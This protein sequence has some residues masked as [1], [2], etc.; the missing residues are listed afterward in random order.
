MNNEIFRAYD[1]RG[2]A[3]VDLTTDVV[4]NIGRAFGSLALEKNISTVVIGRDG[5][6]SGPSLLGA[7]SEG[8][9]LAGIHVVDIGLVPTPVLYFAC[10]LVGSNTGIALTGSHN[11][12]NYNGLKMVI[13]NR[14]LYGDDIQEIRRRIEKNLF[15]SGQGSYETRNVIHSYLE[16]IIK[17]IHLSKSFRIAIDCGNGVAGLLAPTLFRKLGCQV[18]PLYCDVDGTFPNHHP[19]PSDLDNLTDLMRL[20]KEQHCDLGFAFDGDGDR[21]GVVDATGKVIWPDRQ[22]MLFSED[23]L[24]RHPG[25]TI[26]YDVKCSRH[27]GEYIKNHGGK[28]IMWKT[29]HS[30]VKAKMRETNALLAGEMS[31]HIFFKERWYGFDDAL[32][33]ASRLLE[34]LSRK[35]E[36][37]LQIFESLPDSINTPELTLLFDDENKQRQFMQFFLETAQF[38]EAEIST[39]DGIRVDFSDGW[40]LVRP[41]NTTPSLVIRFEAETDLALNRIKDVFRAQ[42][43]EVDPDIKLPF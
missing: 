28:P 27:L 38:S 15:I 25:A 43:L 22:M 24:E 10:D 17:D 32:Y 19:N 16:R 34:I 39:I 13:D 36:S 41:S 4:L 2:I 37:P 9:Q 20:V 8:L 29:G 40:G 18:L 31:G 6:L 5:R 26:I 42:L 3:E 1:I 12:S 21:L 11:P 35:K 30:L 14:T 23:I 33:S 7:L